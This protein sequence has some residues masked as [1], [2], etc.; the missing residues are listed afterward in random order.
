MERISFYVKYTEEFSEELFNSAMIWAKQNC[1]G[2]PRGWCDHYNG[3]K[4]NK[5][6]LFDNWG[7]GIREEIKIDPSNMS[8]GCDNNRQ[9]CKMEISVDELK[10]IIGFNQYEI[11]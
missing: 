6:F 2:V 10:S 11:Y 8:Y 7:L 9:S 1:I 5:Y 4:N 3:L